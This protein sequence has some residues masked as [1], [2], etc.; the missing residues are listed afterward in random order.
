MVSSLDGIIAKK[1]NSISWFETSCNYDKG[2]DAEDSEA[3]LNNIDCYLMGSKN[4]T[5]S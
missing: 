5:P 3:F 4:Y 1:D 2:V